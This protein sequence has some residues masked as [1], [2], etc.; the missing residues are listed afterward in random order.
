LAKY[1]FISAYED[2]P[3]LD[4]HDI[5]RFLQH[6]LERLEPTRDLH[7]H[8]RTTIDTLDYTGDGLNAGSKVVFAAAGEKIRTL[9]TEKPKDF[10][11]F[12][13][14]QASKFIMP[15]IMAVE[16]VVFESYTIENKRL[17]D[18]S[19]RLKDYNLDGIGLIVI[20]DN[21]DFTAASVNN[22]V[23]DVFTKSNPSHD[24]YGVG[25]FI[26]NKHWGCRGPVIIDAR[27]KPHHAPELI[28]DSAVEARVDRLALPGGSLFGII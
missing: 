22:F 14:F 21:A 26:D 18:Y 5:P 9:V 2:D 8:T 19:E 28:K 12:V 4:I 13:D 10:P 6:C 11:S 16:S 20:C 7:F 27:K 15:G 25:S 24:I 3:H 23:W 17:G 1:L